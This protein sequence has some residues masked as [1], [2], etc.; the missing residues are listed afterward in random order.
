MS[1]HDNNTDDDDF[2][3][4]PHDP[5]EAHRVMREILASGR[6]GFSRHAEKALADDDLTTLDFV[7]VIRGGVVEQPELE[8]GSWRYRVRTNR[9]VAV[10]AFRSRR[11]MTAV[12]AWRLK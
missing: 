3:E 7:N 2:A 1:T 4:V 6:L 12:T 10:V 8:N 11:E 9:M 5:Q